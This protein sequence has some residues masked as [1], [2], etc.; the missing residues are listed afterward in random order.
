MLRSTG[1]AKSQRGLSDRTA[2]K[3]RDTALRSTQTDSE[4][5]PTYLV[6]ELGDFFKKGT[7]KAAGINRPFVT[8]GIWFREP[9]CLW[10][11]LSGQVAHGSRICQ[12]TVPWQ[13]NLSGRLISDSNLSPLT[14]L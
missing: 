12:F 9:W 8:F 7:K 10:F 3:G 6:C 4:K 1:V 14:L 11:T 2:G 13:N 5:P